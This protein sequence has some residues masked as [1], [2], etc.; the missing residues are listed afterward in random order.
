MCAGMASPEPLCSIRELR[1]MMSQGPGL[2]GPFDAALVALQ[3][4]GEGREAGGTWGTVE[5]SGFR[6]EI[7]TGATWGLSGQRC[8]SCRRLEL[9]HEGTRRMQDMCHNAC[10]C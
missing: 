4:I 10:L 1:W 6:I 2:L 8:A 9:D 5:G 7:R 3:V